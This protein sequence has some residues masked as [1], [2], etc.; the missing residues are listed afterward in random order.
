M[1]ICNRG[2]SGLQKKQYWNLL[3]GAEDEAA[4]VGLSLKDR[5]RNTG[6][7]SDN[8]GWQAVQGVLC[9][10]T[11]IHGLI[12]TMTRILTVFTYHNKS[13]CI[14]NLGRRESC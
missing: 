10:I 4:R 5:E 8:R 14:D 1:K 13:Q 3:G 6:T 9:R 7:L 12:D 11:R 2:R